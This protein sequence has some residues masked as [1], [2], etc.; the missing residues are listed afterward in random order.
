MNST[1]SSSF[2]QFW[3]Y[4][5][6]SRV[7][8]QEPAASLNATSCSRNVKDCRYFTSF[9]QTLRANFSII[10]WREISSVLHEFY[11]N[12][13]RQSFYCFLAGNIVAISQIL[14]LH[15]AS[16]YKIC[17]FL[18]RGKTCQMTTG[19]KDKHFPFDIG[20]SIFGFSWRS[21]RPSHP[22]CN[23][24]PPE[25]ARQFFSVG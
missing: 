21:G 1:D 24:L 22:G 15:N 19:I 11:P 20:K 3:N 16:L 2:F 6:L 12:V 4:H 23:S 13:A 17:L 18:N 5:L 7:L 8:W 14:S 9:I 10:F 25:E